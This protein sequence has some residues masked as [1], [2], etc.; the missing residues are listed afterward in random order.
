MNSAYHHLYEWGTASAFVTLGQIKEEPVVED[1][2]L[3]VGRVLTVRYSYDERIDDGLST[4]KAIWRVHEI[5]QN[6]QE[7][8]DDRAEMG[9]CQDDS[10]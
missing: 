6:P 2:K 5:L 10:G 9:L 8:L 1:G 7:H 3:V 4:R